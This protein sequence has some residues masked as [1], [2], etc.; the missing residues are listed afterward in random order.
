[1]QQLYFGTLLLSTLLNKHC[2]VSVEMVYKIWVSF[3]APVSKKQQH[4]G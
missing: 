3:K 1:M 2:T 4:D